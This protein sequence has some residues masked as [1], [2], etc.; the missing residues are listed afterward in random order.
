[1]KTVKRY[2]WA[3]KILGAALLIGLA[4]FLYFGETGEQ[5][6]ITFVGSAIIIYSVIRLVPFV[7]TQGSDLIK[8]INI[9]EITIDVMIGIFLIIYF[10][11]FP[12]SEGMGSVFGYLFGPFLILRGA[13]HF[14]GVS[15]G[16]ER[17][18]HALYFFHIG[19]LVV[20]SFILFFDGG[21]E[22]SILLLVIAIFSSGVGVFLIYD[23]GKGYKIYRYEKAVYQQKV[24][25]D[26]T[27]VEKELPVIEE[28]EIEQDSIVS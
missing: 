21:F 25:S 15:A 13:V 4:A 24:T 18:D 19:A 28:P 5:I 7:K 3:L 12:E 2:G 11:I 26:E 14:Y 8:T 22:A 17:S 1:M 6:V 16:K 27:S 23:G 20:G 10:L 9:M